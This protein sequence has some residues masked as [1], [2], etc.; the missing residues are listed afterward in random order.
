M[1]ESCVFSTSTDRRRKT[2][3]ADTCA[4]N[5]VAIWRER[6]TTSLLGIRPK[7][8]TPRSRSDCFSEDSMTEMTRLRRW[9][10]EMATSFEGASMVP[11][12]SCPSWSIAW[13]LKSMA[14]ILK[15]LYPWPLRVLEFERRAGE[16]F[17]RP[18]CFP[19]GEYQHFLRTYLILS[20]LYL[21]L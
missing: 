19:V 13:Y 2:R 11:S 6:M 1:A 4:S 20:E 18:F 9:S 17:S 3:S 15:E 12:R 14:V 8:D 5:K 10:A 16:V 21:L 7:N